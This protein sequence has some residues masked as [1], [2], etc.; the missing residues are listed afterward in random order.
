[1]IDGLKG[2]KCAF[3]TPHIFSNVKKHIQAQIYTSATITTTSQAINQR[4]RS[5]DE[6]VVQCINERYYHFDILENPDI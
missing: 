3:S 6:G 5:W 1:M 2:A 4:P